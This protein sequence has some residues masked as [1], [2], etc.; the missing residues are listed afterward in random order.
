[1]EKTELVEDA[2]VKDRFV[3]ARSSVEKFIGDYRYVDARSAIEPINGDRNNAPE[4]KTSDNVNNNSDERLEETENHCK[5][6]E[7][8]RSDEL[9]QI[10]PLEESE[11]Y[12]E[13]GEDDDYYDVDGYATA[14]SCKS[15]GDNTTGAMTIVLA[16]RVTARHAKE[17][18]AAR[19]YVEKTTYFDEIEEDLGDMTLVAEYSDDIFEYMRKLEVCQYPFVLLARY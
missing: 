11:E 19:L 15:R 13:E 10:S 18:E 14:R 5:A 4:I 7:L 3:D 2:G 9:V 17:L 16:P 8:Y 1:M 12:W 6:I